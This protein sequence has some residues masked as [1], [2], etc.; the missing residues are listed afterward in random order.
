[1]AVLIDDKAQHGPIEVLITVD[2]ETGM[3]G[4]FGLRVVL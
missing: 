2:E 3:T 4:A 1:M